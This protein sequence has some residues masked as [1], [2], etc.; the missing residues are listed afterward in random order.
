MDVLLVNGAHINTQD[1]YGNTPLH[2]AAYSGA[3]AAKYLI[4]HGAEINSKNKNGYTPLHLAAHEGYS[5]FL[6]SSLKI[7]RFQTSTF[8]VL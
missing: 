8:F 1:D 2:W 5:H 6:Q 7:S 4:D 3:F